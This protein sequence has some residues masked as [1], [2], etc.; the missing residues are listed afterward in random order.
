MSTPPGAGS[1]TPRGG[2]TTAPA[3]TAGSDSTSRTMK[4][5]L[6]STNHERATRRRCCASSSR[7]RTTWSESSQGSQAT[8][9]LASGLVGE[10]SEVVRGE[11]PAPEDGLLVRRAH[12]LLEAGSR[13]TLHPSLAFGPGG[14]A[15]GLAI[16]DA[17]I[18]VR[19]APAITGPRA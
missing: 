4:I 10:P 18:R 3:T 12:R 16:D 17:Q 6:S 8:P 11:S 1:L 15:H 2:S 14:V 19:D 13:P 9:S 7:R 5:G